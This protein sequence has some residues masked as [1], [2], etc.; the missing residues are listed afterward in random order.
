MGAYSEQFLPT[1]YQA[2]LA[3]PKDPELQQLM[4][5]VR[6]N[7]QKAMF[8]ARF[9]ETMV[10]WFFVSMPHDLRKRR[11]TAIWRFWF[12]VSCRATASTDAR[13]LSL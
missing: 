6:Q 5:L 12:F 1:K 2:D 11:P 8:A 4:D 10:G 7:A 9:A 13:C 3:S